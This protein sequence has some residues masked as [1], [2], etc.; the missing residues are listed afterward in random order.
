MSKE[1]NANRKLTIARAMAEAIAQ[2]MRVD[3]QVFVMGEDIAALGGVFG[4]T[5]GLLE[6]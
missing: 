1:T 5:R 3:P 2:E 4:N 6:E